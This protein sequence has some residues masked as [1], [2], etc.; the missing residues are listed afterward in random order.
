MSSN[1]KLDQDLKGKIVDLKLYRDMIGS[2]LYLITN[3][4]EIIFSIYICTHYL[5]NPKESHVMIVKCVIRYLI[6]T[7]NVGLWFSK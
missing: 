1:C 2:L 4:P 3:R 7:Q 5:S 6:D